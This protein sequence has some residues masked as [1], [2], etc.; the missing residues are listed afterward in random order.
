[1]VTIVGNELENI[2]K[3]TAKT[4]QKCWGKWKTTLLFLQIVDSA[5]LK[6]NKK[7]IEWETGN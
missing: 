3:N 5:K 6:K 1:M 2:L 4:M 7:N